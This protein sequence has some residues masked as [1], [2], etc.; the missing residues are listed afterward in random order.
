MDNVGPIIGRLQPPGL[1]HLWCRQD[2]ACATLHGNVDALKPLLTRSG[3]TCPKFL[4]NI[5]TCSFN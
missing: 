5:K 2:K 1:R 4:I 3:Y